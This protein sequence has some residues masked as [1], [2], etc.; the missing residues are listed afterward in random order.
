[1]ENYTLDLRFYEEGIYKSMNSMEKKLLSEHTVKD[2][3]LEKRVLITTTK[4]QYDYNGTVRIAPPV[5]RIPFRKLR[6]RERETLEAMGIE[7]EFEKGFYRNINY[8]EIT[9]DEDY[10]I[11][12]AVYSDRVVLTEL[13]QEIPFESARELTPDTTLEYMLK[14]K[15]DWN[16][17]LR[18]SLLP[19]QP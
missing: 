3:E 17:I 9:P 5:G 18:L 1:M 14:G 8:I 13:G 2:L 16:V 12:N 19:K 11:V 7:K 6:K 4:G 15:T 10:L